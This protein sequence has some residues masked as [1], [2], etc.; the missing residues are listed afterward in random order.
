[1]IECIPKDNFYRQLN[2]VLNLK[3]LYKVTLPFYDVNAQK[4]IDSVVFFKLSLVGYLKNIK[5][6][7]SNITDEITTT[8][9]PTK[10]ITALEKALTFLNRFQNNINLADA[11]IKEKNYNRAIIYYEKSSAG[12]CINDPNTIKKLIQCYFKVDDFDDVITSTKKIHLKKYF[13]KSLFYYEL[14]LEQKGTFGEAEDQ[15]KKINP[16]FSNYKERMQLAIFLIR[17]KKNE[18]A[19]ELLEEIQVELKVWFLITKRN[20]D[21]FFKNLKKF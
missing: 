5:N 21:L 1:M 8:I 19:K 7:V 6:N 15:L 13:K 20:I 11:F 2:T 12:H 9:I 18:D 4:S 3:F 17:R 10:K 14:S 16:H